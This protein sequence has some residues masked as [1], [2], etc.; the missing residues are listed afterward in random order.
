MK[1]FDDIWLFLRLHPLLS[2]LTCTRAFVFAAR[3]VQA[4][5]YRDL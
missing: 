5:E 3:R 1:T 2:L 4:I